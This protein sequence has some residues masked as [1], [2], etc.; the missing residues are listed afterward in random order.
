MG[1]PLTPK[2]ALWA[3]LPEELTVKIASAAFDSWADGDEPRWSVM[4]RN[5]RHMCQINRTFLRAFWPLHL[6]LRYE[7]EDPRRAYSLVEG[8]VQLLHKRPRLPSTTT[9]SFVHLLVY[10]SCTYKALQPNGRR[11][12]GCPCGDSNLKSQIQVCV[13]GQF[14]DAMTLGLIQMYASGTLPKPNKDVQRLVIRILSSL[15]YYVEKFHVQNL[16]Q[17]SLKAHL[18]QAYAVVDAVCA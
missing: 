7:I 16:R 2:S 14:L 1:K 6:M 13:Q 3:S 8:I 18:I 11:E 12:N 5:G 10:L 17:P 4:L 15:F 9:Y